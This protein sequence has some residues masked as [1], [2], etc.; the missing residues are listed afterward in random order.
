MTLDNVIMQKVCVN[1]K[2]YEVRRCKACRK[3]YDKNYYINK[4]KQQRD[5]DE[6]ATEKRW[7][8]E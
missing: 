8:G 5:H 3:Q 1:D 6:H 4:V 2:I 7:S